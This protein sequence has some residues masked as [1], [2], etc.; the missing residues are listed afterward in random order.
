MIYIYIY[1]YYNTK[2]TQEHISA[3]E[4]S[5][6]LHPNLCLQRESGIQEEVGAFLRRE[7]QIADQRAGLPCWMEE[8][9]RS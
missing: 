5:C 8:M 6:H 1:T 9:V 2:P 3:Y 4:C 7:L